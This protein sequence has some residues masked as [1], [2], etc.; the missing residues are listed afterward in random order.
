MLGSAFMLYLKQMPDSSLETTRVFWRK[1]YWNATDKEA[2]DPR[3]WKE[4]LSER[5][6]ITEGE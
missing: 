1:K 5:E 2:Y 6:V 4:V 3:P